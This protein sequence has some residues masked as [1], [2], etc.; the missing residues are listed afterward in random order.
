MIFLFSIIWLPRGQWLISRF[1]SQLMLVGHLLQQ[2]RFKA[3][4]MTILSESSTLSFG[5]LSIMMLMSIT[6]EGS[7]EQANSKDKERISMIL[8]R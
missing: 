6:I 5:K 7:K 2:Q 8:Q 1:C 4:W 3:V